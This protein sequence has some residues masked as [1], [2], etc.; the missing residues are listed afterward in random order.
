MTGA[1][2]YLYAT[3]TEALLFQPLLMLCVAINTKISMF[4]DPFVCLQEYWCP[5]ITLTCNLLLGAVELGLIGPSLLQIHRYCVSLR[6]LPGE[7]WLLVNLGYQLL[8]SFSFYKIRKSFPCYVYLG[9]PI[10]NGLGWRILHKFLK[11]FFQCLLGGR[12]GPV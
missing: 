3:W 1:S 5:W 4:Q 12:I 10:K 9:Y 8:P 2:V 11:L 7:H 6:S